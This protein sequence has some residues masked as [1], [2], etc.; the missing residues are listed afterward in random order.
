LNLFRV[1]VLKAL[2]HALNGCIFDLSFIIIQ[3]GCES[4]NQV[5]VS[6]IF[7]KSISKLSEILGKGKSDLPRFVFT[8]GNQSL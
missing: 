6:N 5:A 8:G 4:L 1:K 3:K 2:S 7:A